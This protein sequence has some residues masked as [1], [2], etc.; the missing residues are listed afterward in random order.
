MKKFWFYSKFFGINRNVPLLQKKLL[1]H[2]KTCWFRFDPKLRYRNVCAFVSILVKSKGPLQITFHASATVSRP[3]MALS[4][5]DG[6][7][8]HSNCLYKHSNCLYKHSYGLY[9]HFHG[10]YKHSRPSQVLS[11]ALRFLL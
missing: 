10:L 9:M 8:K 3:L 4:R 2:I 1:E 6:I 7:Y 11:L 5:G